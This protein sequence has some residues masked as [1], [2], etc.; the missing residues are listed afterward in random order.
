MR[1]ME[2]EDRKQIMKFKQCVDD[3]MKDFKQD[4][5][6]DEDSPVWAYEDA[7]KARIA[8]DEIIHLFRVQ[9]YVE[10]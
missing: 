6:R 3:Y 8:L 2:D 5:E 9:G 7:C 4:F 1:Q 10:D